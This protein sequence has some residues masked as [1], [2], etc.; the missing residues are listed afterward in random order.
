L[1]HSRKR[2]SCRLCDSSRIDLVIP[3]APTPLAEK[4]FHDSETA[5]SQE[6]YDMDLY[7]CRDCGCVQLLEVVDPKV[8]WDDYTYHSGQTRGILDHF[9]ECAQSIF[10][11][12]SPTKESLVVDIGSNDGSFL[13]CFKKRGL[14]VLGIDPATE[15]ARKATQSG[16]ETMA[17]FLT[18]DLAEQVKSKHGPASIVTAFNVFAHTDDMQAMAQ[19]IRH[20]LAPDG[21][22]VFEVSYLLDIIDGMLLGTFFHEHLCHH[23]V[24]SLDKFLERNGLQLI[25]VQ[26]V[27]IQGGSLIGTA[28][29]VGGSLPVSP[30]VQ[31][32]LDLEGKRMLNHSDGIRIFADKLN[33]LHCE[34]SERS[35]AWKDQG[36][37]IAGF[38]AARS[39]NTLIAQMGLG[40]SISFIVDDHPQKVNK[41]IGGYGIPVL[42][43]SELNQRQPDYTFILAW[44]HAKKIIESNQEYLKSGGKFVVCCPDLKIIDASSSF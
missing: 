29:L 12:H 20:L 2:K 36:K 9:E 35:A 3:L 7:M 11:R 4:Y 22:F 26:R 40:T 33:N 13:R 27:S 37:S 42:P 44:I 32:S 8:L 14:S 18:S 39:G 41:Y 30:S 31:A 24:S 10:E 38:G 23:S 19:S 21:L 34:V 16:I 1:K 43:T 17:E 25:D 5:G 28:Q 6:F 15:I